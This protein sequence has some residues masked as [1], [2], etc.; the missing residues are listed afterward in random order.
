[1]NI[2]PR[3]SDLDAVVQHQDNYTRLEHLRQLEKRLDDQIKATVQLLADTRRELKA[4]RFTEFPT[5]AR[6]VPLDELLRFAKNISKF[7]VPPTGALSQQPTVTNGSEN[8]GTGEGD[9]AVAGSPTVHESVKPGIITTQPTP[10]A[11][12]EA[13]GN[14]AEDIYKVGDPGVGWQTL[15]EHHK[16]WLNQFA[17]TPFMPWPNDDFI[18]AGALSNIQTLI[19]QG[20]DPGMPGAPTAD[21]NQNQAPM[22]IAMDDDKEHEN[23]VS[24]PV[25]SSAVERPRASRPTFD[26]FDF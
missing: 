13:A 20:H 26:G 17:Q 18:K 25:P 8:A 11:T 22:D 2:L 5:D 4:A 16:S 6:P 23:G 12:H 3:S 21:K 15:A 9:I 7:T 19:E 10:S 24:I 1:M 14:G